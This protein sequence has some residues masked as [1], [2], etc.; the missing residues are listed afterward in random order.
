MNVSGAK[1]QATSAFFDATSYDGEV[2]LD[3]RVPLLKGLLWND[4]WTAVKTAGSLSEA[5]KAKF[6]QDVMTSVVKIA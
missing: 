2:A 3:A 5:A 4:Q 1:T 6:R